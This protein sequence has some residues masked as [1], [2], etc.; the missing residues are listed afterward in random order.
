MSAQDIID[1][2][3]LIRQRLRNPPNAVYDPGID[4]TRKSTHHKG[5]EPNPDPP[6]KKALE[7]PIIVEP[8]YPPMDIRFP[9]TFDDIVEAVSIHYG[10]TAEAIR[11]PCRRSHICFARFV[12]VYLSLRIL[13]RSLKSMGRELGR[14]HTTI[15]NCKKRINEIIAGNSQ[16][17]AEVSMIETYVTQKR[18]A[19]NEA[20]AH[21]TRDQS[22]IGLQSDDGNLY[23]ERA[24]QE[25]RAAGW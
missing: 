23:V 17:A 10:V 11:S 3:K 14:D 7:K 9:I 2:A 4:L 22:S 18:D 16:V 5:N 19:R 6:T 25:Q 8:S 1:Q 15:L 24:N 13:K 12:V 21:A 20:L